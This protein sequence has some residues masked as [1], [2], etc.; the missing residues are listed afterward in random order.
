M[1]KL[2]ARGRKELVRMVLE[3]EVNDPSRLSDWERTTVALMSDGQVLRKLDVRFKSDGQKHSYGWTVYRKAKG[4]TV[5]KF[6]KLYEAV[7]FK[8]A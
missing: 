3:T 2:G 4:V 5:E 6:V 8:K 7:G 1:A